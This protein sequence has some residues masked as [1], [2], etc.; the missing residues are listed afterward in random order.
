MVSEM[1]LFGVL[2]DEDVGPAIRKFIFS[3]S[4]S[5]PPAFFFSA[6]SLSDVAASQ[7]PLRQR[8]DFST[9]SQTVPLV[10][11]AVEDV[12]RA[13]IGSANTPVAGMVTSPRTRG[14]CRWS[15]SSS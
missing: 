5:F 7:V 12:G 3:N 13:R 15:F 9:P 6:R 4:L 14:P 10:W 11:S 8:L 1:P 2:N